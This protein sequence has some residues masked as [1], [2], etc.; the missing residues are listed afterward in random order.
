MHRPPQALSLVVLPHEKQPDVS[1][2][3][4]GEI[5][6]DVGHGCQ[7]RPAEQPDVVLL[8]ACEAGWARGKDLG[9]VAGEGRVSTDPAGVIGSRLEQ[10]L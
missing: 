7:S 4:L 3:L 9:G 6:D 8:F 1:V 10:R 5:A 2:M